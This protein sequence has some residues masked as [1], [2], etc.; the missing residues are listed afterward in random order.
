MRK[1]KLLEKDVLLLGLSMLETKNCNN[2]E[3]ALGT[4]V[5]GAFFYI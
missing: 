1:S 2:K 3:K 5:S 4:K